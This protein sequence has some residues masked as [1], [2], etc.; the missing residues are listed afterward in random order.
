MSPVRYML[1]FTL[2]VVFAASRVS[3]ASVVC[4]EEVDLERT[5][6]MVCYVYGEGNAS[7]RVVSINGVNVSQAEH[8]FYA[9]D[10]RGEF[11]YQGEA[12]SLPI[13]I[14]VFM[15]RLLRIYTLK[16]SWNLYWVYYNKVN[17]VR[18]LISEENGSQIVDVQVYIRGSPGKDFWYFVY[19]GL[20][21][22]LALLALYLVSLL[23]PN[24][25]GTKKATETITTAGYFFFVFGSAKILMLFAAGLVYY[26]GRAASEVPADLVLSWSSVMLVL[27]LLTVLDMAAMPSE[28][29]KQTWL[30]GMEWVPV[31]LFMLS[32]RMIL[33]SFLFLV[34][35]LA[36]VRV[37]PFVEGMRKASPLASPLWA[38]LI[39][40][41]VGGEL[42]FFAILLFLSLLYPYL[43]HV[44]IPMEVEEEF[45]EEDGIIRVTSSNVVVESIPTGDE[46]LWTDNPKKRE[47]LRTDPPSAKELLARLDSVIRQ[48]QWEEKNLEN[49]KINQS[50]SGDQVNFTTFKTE[51]SSD[52]IPLGH[53]LG[54]TLAD[55][56]SVKNQRR[57]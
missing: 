45:V 34:V 30:T 50:S 22:V 8:Y 33:F 38:F 55:Y 10:S 5:S 25:G 24:S 14:E 40:G 52:W 21:V 3:A 35:Y 12:G 29:R 7:V 54:F 53:P 49:D 51:L 41:Y 39:Y 42:V 2:I 36:L 28:K 43:L 44:L 6:E 46:T 18:F 23:R 26:L 4:P 32:D 27:L 20:F 48:I 15:K 31:S 57:R 1:V 16:P 37:K 13:K 56:E 9:Y 17:H 47:G 19:L 11:L